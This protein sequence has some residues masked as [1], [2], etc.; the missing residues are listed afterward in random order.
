[1]SNSKQF[2]WRVLLWFCAWR[3][4]CQCIRQIHTGSQ[5]LLAWAYPSFTFQHERWKCCAPKWQQ[6]T[7]WLFFLFFLAWTWW[8]GAS[9]VWY[10]NG[11]QSDLSGNHSG[12]PLS[13]FRIGCVEWPWH[14][15][16]MFHNSELQ[17]SWLAENNEQ[18]VVGT[19]L[20]VVAR[21]CTY[22]CPHESSW[23]W[24]WQDYDGNKGPVKNA[25]LED[26][27]NILWLIR[28]IVIFCFS[29]F[30]DSLWLPK[31]SA[32]T[33]NHVRGIQIA[34]RLGG[35]ISGLR[36]PSWP[37]GQRQVH[38]LKPAFGE[39]RANLCWYETILAIYNG[40]IYIYMYIMEIY[41]MGIYQNHRKPV[42]M[43]QSRSQRRKQRMTSTNSHVGVS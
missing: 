8:G 25:I 7:P 41:I 13:T 28:D 39:P 29:G 34:F 35:R 1:M 26:M 9:G 40:D 38:S 32:T 22:G 37:H 4:L 5:T 16:R 20:H 3:H 31:V 15:P 10:G 36:S 23:H 11:P 42:K 6:F 17:G 30:T 18:H 24:I 14:V 21:R 2:L 27:K 43:A 33:V 19:S 12:N